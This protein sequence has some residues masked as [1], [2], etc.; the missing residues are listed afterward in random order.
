MSSLSACGQSS[1]IG[2]CSLVS[3]VVNDV[4]NA[5]GAAPRAAERSRDSP[6]NELAGL[7]ESTTERANAGADGADARA[8]HSNAGAG[9]ADTRAG[10][11]AGRRDARAGHVGDRGRHAACRVRGAADGPRLALHLPPLIHGLLLQLQGLPRLCVG[12]LVVRHLQYSLQEERQ[13]T[14]AN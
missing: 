1:N 12:E 4:G 3:S 7:A 5:A 14:A 10:N 13:T 9:R 2:S 6:A 8:N 11:G